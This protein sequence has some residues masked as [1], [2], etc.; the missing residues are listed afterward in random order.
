MS[1]RVIHDLVLPIVLRR[2][3][4]MGAGISSY[5]IPHD[6]ALED[7]LDEQLSVLLGICGG[8]KHCEDL[9]RAIKEAKERDPEGFEM[10]IHQLLE[11]YIN[12]KTK[13]IEA[14][15]KKKHEGPPDRFKDLRKNARKMW[16]YA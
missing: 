3:D 7:F 16:R 14:L 15:L 8:A 13:I 10:L 11:K 4:R 2:L 9:E 5:D 12:L 1:R 6:E